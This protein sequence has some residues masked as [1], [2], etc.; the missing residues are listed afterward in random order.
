VLVVS[1]DLDCHADASHRHRVNLENTAELLR[2][3]AGQHHV[4]VTWTCQNPSESLVARAASR[5]AGDEIALSVTS[6]SAGS[7]PLRRHVAQQLTRA[8]VAGLSV[9]TLALPAARGRAALDGHDA[10][11]L[12]ITAIRTTSE[13]SRAASVGLFSR[14]MNSLAGQRTALPRPR[15]LRYGLWEVPATIVHP[16]RQGRAGGAVTLTSP[17]RS[18]DRLIRFHPYLHV[19]IDVPLVAEMGGA[20]IEPIEQLLK[21]AGQA[22]LAGALRIGTI[23]SLTASFAPARA[24][25]PAQSILKRRAA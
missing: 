8:R 17:R 25:S 6:A 21:L 12:G 10:S 14:L 4:P 22:S 9:S 16:W 20:A 11:K 1:F 5:R 15:K 23:A 18:I 3:L 2:S 13:A 7:M 24:V 19:A